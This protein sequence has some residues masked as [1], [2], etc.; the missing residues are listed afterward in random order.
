MDKIPGIK[1][2]APAT[3][4]NVAVGYDILGFA[5]FGPGDDIKVSQGTEPGL[6][7]SMIHN[8]YNKLPKDPLK[9]TAGVAA[10]SVMEAIGKSDFPVNFEIIKN[11]PFA[12]GMGSSAA[13]AVAGAMGINEFFGNPL[14]KME[15]LPHAMKGEQVADG[16]YHADNVAPSLL[17]GIT[18]IRSN[19]EHDV[20][21]LPSPEG[22]YCCLIHP[23][24]K[25]LTADSREILSDK[26]DLNSFIKQTG[27]LGAF[28]ASLYRLDLDLLER[29]LQDVVI[30]PQRA[31]LIPHFYDLKEIALSNKALGFSISGAGPSLFAL[32]RNSLDAENVGK[33]IKA[34][35]K[36]NNI[37]STVYISKI[38]NEGAIK[39]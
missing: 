38:N 14:T 7:I 15:L 10:L 36:E 21:K 16:A 25:I 9:N 35:L 4:A 13:S 27:N 30:E 5:I 11:M 23:N 18:L 6:T 1:V 29:S 3:V 39:Y 32:C 19:E 12:S 20:I 26:V 37:K 24:I 33:G 8:G 28:V 2:Y 17:G 31:K 34:F 22:L